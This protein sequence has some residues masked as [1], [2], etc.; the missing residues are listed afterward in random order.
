MK[1]KT[2][3]IAGAGIAGLTAA[4]NLAKAGYEVEVYDRV[5]DSGQRFCG[6]FQGI[7]NW[8]YKQDALDFLNDINI[9]LNFDYQGVDKFSVW[10][11]DDCHRDFK[12]S[13]PLCYLVKRG[14]GE[15]CL[16]QGLKKQALVKGVKIFYNHFMKAK[17]AD[18]IATGPFFNDPEVDGIVSGYVF[19]TDLEDS[20]ILIL[21]DRCALDGCSYFLVNDGLAT[22][23]TCIFGNYKKLGEY[24]AKTIELCKRYKKFK[25]EDA[26]KF[27]GTANFFLPKKPKDKKVYI[28][29]AGGF[30][31]YLW[32]FGM[33]YAMRSGY[34]AARSV[35][36][37]KD[38]YELCQKNLFPQMKTSV[39]NRL[40]FKMLNNKSYRW[41]IKYYTK[42][43]KYPVEFVRKLYNPSLFKN[44]LFPFAKVILR[45][46]VKDPR[47]L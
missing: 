42:R 15:G 5:G 27:S 11:P 36:E 33:M 43:I 46:H 44:L 26:K 6:D 19:K 38:F 23:A 41:L 16:D 30:Q 45:K 47:N 7:E 10:A 28:G 32:G 25:M 22:I 14:V 37:S 13:R 21:D 12:L 17:E 29:E 24:R 20:N 1:K 31:D 8:S 34:Y 39:V 35:I 9:E 40:F 2:I 4:I 3:K 18:I